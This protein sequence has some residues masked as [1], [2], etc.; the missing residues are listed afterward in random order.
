MTNQTLRHRSDLG[1]GKQA[2]VSQIIN[3]TVEAGL[4]PMDES[5]GA[6]RYAKYLPF[7]G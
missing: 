6:K 1:D 7:W 2:I 4:I 3:A 5:S